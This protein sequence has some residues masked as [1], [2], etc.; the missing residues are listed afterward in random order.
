MVDASIGGKTG[1]NFDHLKNNIGTFY[2]AKHIFCDVKF[3][4]SLPDI[5]I[6][7]G[8]GEV[9]KHAI[10]QDYPLW[11]YLKSS[12]PNKLD[13]NYLTEKSANIKLAIVKNDPYEKNIRKIIELRAYYR[14]C[15]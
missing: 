12:D 9:F 1:F 3:L 10:I 5:E 13:Y 2:E 8:M 7:S 11:K 14:S 4:K 15:H 6:L